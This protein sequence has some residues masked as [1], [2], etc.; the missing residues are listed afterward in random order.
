MRHIDSDS[1]QASQLRTVSLG[2][3]LYCPKIGRKEELKDGPDKTSQGNIDFHFYLGTTSYD[4]PEDTRITKKAFQDA[5]LFFLF[6]FRILGPK[7]QFTISILL[8][9]FGKWK[10]G[11][12]GVCIYASR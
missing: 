12:L 8:I 5:L 3:I 9:A 4:L 6:L 1:F 7:I 2:Y 11:G 10:V